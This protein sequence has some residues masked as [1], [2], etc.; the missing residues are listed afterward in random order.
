MSSLQKFAVSKAYSLNMTSLIQCTYLKKKSVKQ[1]EPS[2]TF[3]FTCEL[4]LAKSQLQKKQLNK[5]GTV[6]KHHALTPSAPVKSCSCN[7]REDQFEFW[8]AV[9]VIYYIYYI[10]YIYII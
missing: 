7:P 9:W 5:M 8:M 1:V 2:R 3:T 6:P 10:Y 4:F